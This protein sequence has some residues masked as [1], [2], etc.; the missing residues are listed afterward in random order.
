[1]GEVGPVVNV[2][3]TESPNGSVSIDSAESSPPF[4]EDL[5]LGTTYNFEIQISY[6]Y[7]DGKSGKLMMYF[8]ATDGEVASEPIEGTG[9]RTTTTLSVTDTVPDDM[10]GD[11]F[12][13]TV[14]IRDSN[15]DF[16]AGDDDAYYVD[17]GDN[18]PPEIDDYSPDTDI[19][20]ISKT[21][22]VDFS[23][24][25]SDPDGDELTHSWYFTDVDDNTGFEK[26]SSNVGDTS[27]YSRTFDETGDFVV[28]AEV[29]DGDA[30]DTID[31]FVE[32]SPSDGDTPP[33]I[34]RV[35]PSSDQIT[36]NKGDTQE[37]EVE[38]SDPD[39]ALETVEWYVD[40]DRE[41]VRHLGAGSPQFDAWSWSFE[42]ATESTVEAVV[43]DAND[44]TDSTT[45][46]IG[47]KTDHDDLAIDHFEPTS[48]TLDIDTGDTL[49]FSVSATGGSDDAP[50]NVWYV[51][52][53]GGSGGLQE[54]ASNVGEGS[55]YA[56]T[57][58]ESGTYFIEVEV[59]DETGTDA[60][61][62]TVTVDEERAISFDS[63]ATKP[64]SVVE[65][66][67]VVRIE[68]TLKNEGTESERLTVHY[69]ITDAAGDNV[70][71][72]SENVTIEAG[73]VVTPSIE[74]EV[75]SDVTAGGADV[76]LRVTT[77][78]EPDTTVATE[79]WS[80]VI[81]VRDSAGSLTVRT[82][83]SEGNPVTGAVIEVHTADGEHVDEARTNPGS[84]T[85][86][87]LS[88]GTYEYTIRGE[89]FNQSATFPLEITDDNSHV[90]TEWWFDPTTALNGIV[91][92]KDGDAL[93]RNQAIELPD[94]GVSTT[95]DADGWFEFSTGIPYGT[96]AVRIRDDDGST[97]YDDEL[98][99][100]PD[101]YVSIKADVPQDE[102]EEDERLSDLLTEEDLFVT[103]VVRYFQ[104]IEWDDAPLQLGPAQIYGLVR[105]ATT[106]LLDI[107]EGIWTLITNLDAIIDT[108]RALFTISLEWPDEII[109]SL[110][111][112]AGAFN[113]KQREDNPFTTDTKNYHAFQWGWTLGYGV[114][115]FWGGGVAVRGGREAVRYTN[116]QRRIGDAVDD[117]SVPITSQTG[118][119]VGATA[120]KLQNIRH[121]E[122]VSRFLSDYDT[123]ND[124]IKHGS[125]ATPLRTNQASDLMKELSE[126]H[127]ARRLL[128]DRS[129]LLQLPGTFTIQFVKQIPQ[130][131]PA[132]VTYVLKTYDSDD[133]E[134]DLVVA[135]REPGASNVQVKEIWEVT[136]QAGVANTKRREARR[137]L[138]RIQDQAKT[139][140]RL[141]DTPPSAA[142]LSY[143]SFLSDSI[144][145]RVMGPRGDSDDWDDTLPYS[146]KEYSE[147]AEDMIEEGLGPDDI[148]SFE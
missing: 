105:G 140:Q 6:D 129:E 135:S 48:G 116:V 99:V 128:R 97:V 85:I 47:V 23:V 73:G 142:G 148:Q 45:W 87:D 34:S 111:A 74:W 76:S 51:D 54:V 17:P 9:N 32:V 15:G 117:V 53:P 25:A 100:G 75:V 77:S 55:Q 123:L 10:G 78:A 132:G 24:T 29:S 41:Q 146:N 143:D 141:G 63:I 56:H 1:M 19:I 137:T 96:H 110:Y 134:L 27:E 38:V 86:S 81:S 37:F 26:V 3:S 115:S 65:S 39:E 13:V 60:Q 92:S 44:N 125:L 33:S 130:N 8:P 122:L 72:G 70:I 50:T 138:S 106:A 114:A 31:W 131:P 98:S 144:A 113:E 7:E 62:W 79:T 71:T 147:A 145:I 139:A 28:E 136:S 90:E 118:G 22:T 104:G 83:S 11:D 42:E 120:A 4:D 57:F 66:G 119:G 80:D 91:F 126:T 64:D 30:T 112:I 18:T 107:V 102:A 21:D 108:L 67:D 121:S 2:T 46:V 101:P 68:P 36:V 69:E 40:G 5:V 35:T 89:E 43:T 49:E 103:S 109:E 95:T 16:V 82:R 14:I 88:P 94:H 12:T 61:G 84:A 127:A 52:E 124:R 58:E 93:V 59:S 20:S 133:G